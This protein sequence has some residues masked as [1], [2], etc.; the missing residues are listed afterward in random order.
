[1]SSAMAA[2]AATEATMRS[3]DVPIEA[4]SHVTPAPAIA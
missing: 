1:M 2:S 3:R 4:M